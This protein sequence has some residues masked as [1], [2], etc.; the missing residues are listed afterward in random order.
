MDFVSPKGRKTQPTTLSTITPIRSTMAHVLL[1]LKD[2]NGTEDVHDFDGCDD[3]DNVVSLRRDRQ[4]PF[5]IFPN[6]DNEIASRIP[7]Y[8]SE[9][10]SR[11]YSTSQQLSLS[12]V[13]NNNSSDQSHSDASQ[14]FSSSHETEVLRVNFSQYVLIILFSRLNLLLCLMILI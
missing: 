11:C 10:S 3:Q 1:Q 13:L 8:S 7:M 14:Q 5:Y 9:I 2:C 12:A 4:D 6:N